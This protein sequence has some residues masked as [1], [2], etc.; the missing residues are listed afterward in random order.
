MREHKRAIIF[1]GLIFLLVFLGN[2]TAGLSVM[3]NHKAIA[4]EKE[5][6]RFLIT[7]PKGDIFHFAI[8]IPASGRAPLLDFS[9]SM[10]ILAGKDVEMTL[11]VN[12]ESVECN[13]LQDHGLRT[14]VLTAPRD[15]GTFPQEHFLAA[16]Q[17]FDVSLEFTTLPP[18]GSTLWLIWVQSCKD[19]LL[20][21]VHLTKQVEVRIEEAGMMRSMPFS[22]ANKD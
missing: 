3:R 19:M 8:G 14:F 16:G 18:K 10:R 1:C 13:W 7:C 6:I 5:R 15:G 20:E 12:K 11:S 17:T 21:R 9:G 4:I 22:G 2:Y